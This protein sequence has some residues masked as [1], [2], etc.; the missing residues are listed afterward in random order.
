M[1]ASLELYTKAETRKVLLKSCGAKKCNRQSGNK[2]EMAKELVVKSIIG[3]LI[4][5]YSLMYTNPN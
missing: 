1:K 5:Q 2:H 3:N 4:Q